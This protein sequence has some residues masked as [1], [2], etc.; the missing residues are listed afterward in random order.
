[1][2]YQLTFTPTGETGISDGR[3]TTMD[4]EPGRTVAL[5]DVLRTWF[6]TGTSSVLGTLEIRPLTKSSSATSSAAVRGLQPFVTFASSRTFNVT[7]NGTFGQYIPAVPFANFISRATNAA[8]SPALSLQQIAQSANFR[9]NLGLVEGSGTPASLLVS[10]YG[11]LGQKMTEFDVNLTGGQHL[12]LGSIL[13]QKGLQVNDGRIEVRVTSPGGKVTAYAS[14]LD[15]RTNDS[16]LVSP[17]ALT[18]NG[19]TKFV[20]PGVAELSGG[21]PW[22]TDARIF[23]AS[24]EPVRATVTFQSLNSTGDPQSATLDFAPNEVKKLDRVLLNM[25]GITNDGG[26]LHISTTTA[27]NL[28]ATARTYRPDGNGGTFGQ[29]IQAVTPNEAVSL[30]SRPLQL[31]QVEQSERLRSN[32]GLAE[33]TGQ[34]ALVEVTAIPPDSKVSPVLRIQLAPNQFRQLNS[35]LQQMGLSDTHNARISVKVIQGQGRVTAYASVI[36]S[37]TAD[38][39]FVPAQ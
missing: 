17:V 18:G 10:V 12:Q 39:T 5:D 19:S 36:D 30:G 37:L 38:P 3:Q 20:L 28:I 6:G 23:N 16:L 24:A 25:F 31:L 21:I 11:D 8:A 34:P 4:I 9:T 2:R 14:V 22:Q 26:A 13:A 33:V 27:A 32:L 35:I 29:F 1:M 7:T 15:N